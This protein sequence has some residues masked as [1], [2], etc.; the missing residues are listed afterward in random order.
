MD[1]Q[2][3]LSKE[4]IEEIQQYILADNGEAVVHSLLDI[5]EADIAEILDVV[6]M[7]EAKYIFQLLEDEK[8]KKGNFTTK[9]LEDFVLKPV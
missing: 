4:F 7:Y 6:S 3:K 8:F 9:F 1:L 2:F 5:H